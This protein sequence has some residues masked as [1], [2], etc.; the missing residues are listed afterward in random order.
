MQQYPHRNSSLSLRLLKDKII[1]NIRICVP[2]Y[3]FIKAIIVKLSSLFMYT[4]L[5]LEEELVDKK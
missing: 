5:K 3:F 1:K 2:T 4:S